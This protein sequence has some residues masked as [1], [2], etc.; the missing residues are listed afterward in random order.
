MTQIEACI[1]RPITTLTT[2]TTN[3]NGHTTSS[4]GSSSPLLLLNQHQTGSDEFTINLSS[5]QLTSNNNNNN[6]SNIQNSTINN[7][8]NN[9]NTVDIDF[10]FSSNMNI[11]NM[12]M[13]NTNDVRVQVY[14]CGTI[15][16]VYI[17]DQSRLEELLDLFRQICQFDK[18]QLF[19]IKWVDEEG[20]PCTLSSQ[21]ELDEA[22]RLYFIN[23]E[24]ELTIHI[25]ANIPERPGNYLF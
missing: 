3:N 14:Y 5:I 1:Q 4:S 21:I 2:T 16:V 18:Q 25:F 22:L 24:T 20:D 11:M 10:S 15:M 12:N 6:H 8:N 23:K 9:E 17:K 7:N 19:T 13:N